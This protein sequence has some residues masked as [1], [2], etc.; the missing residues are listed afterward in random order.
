MPQLL[1]GNIYSIFGII[2]INT[3]N[4]NTYHVTIL[5]VIIIHTIKSADL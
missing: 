4:S 2:I 3:I 5:Y 1:N